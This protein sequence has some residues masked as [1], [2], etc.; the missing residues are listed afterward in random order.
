VLAV[1]ALSEGLPAGIRWS[2]VISMAL[3]AFA[4]AAWSGRKIANHAVVSSRVD[5]GTNIKSKDG[6][7]VQDVSIA[8]V[9]QDTRVGTHIRSK[10]LTHVRGI[11]IGK[12]NLTKK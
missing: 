5:V 12:Q 10:R 11:R 1:T 8:P 6:V 7:I 4:A 9:A 2:L 3:I